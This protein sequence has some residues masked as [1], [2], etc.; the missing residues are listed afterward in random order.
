MKA[1]QYIPLVMEPES[2]MYNDP[3]IVLDFASLYPSIIMAYNYCYSTSLGHIVDH[4]KNGEPNKP[5]EFGC[6]HLKVI[7]KYHKVAST[8][9]SRFVTHLVF[10]HT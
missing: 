1:P 3:L 10:K 8:N 9:A 6:T 2:R 7:F 4:M 5:F